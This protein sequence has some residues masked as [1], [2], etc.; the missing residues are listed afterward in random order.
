MSADLAT[1]LTVLIV[2]FALATTI[3]VAACCQET[4]DTDNT[5]GYDQDRL[6]R[7]QT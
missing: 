1:A 6:S 3:I 5:P 2:V 7:R 4:P